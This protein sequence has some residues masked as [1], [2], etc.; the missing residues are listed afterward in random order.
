MRKVFMIIAMALF[1]VG[2]SAN[3]NEDIIPLSVETV[4]ALELNTQIANGTLIALNNAA[5]YG[6]TMGCIS[7]SYSTMTFASWDTESGTG[8][9][10]VYGQGGS[11]ATYQTTAKQAKA[12]CNRQE[13]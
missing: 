5:M 8:T 1:T 12:I 10:T 3:T 2:M 9:V 4:K 6:E 7:F 11:S 13:K